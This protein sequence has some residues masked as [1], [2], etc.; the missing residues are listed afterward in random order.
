MC[1]LGVNRAKEGVKSR[2]VPGFTFNSRLVLQAPHKTRLS[3]SWHHRSRLHVIKTSPSLCYS[4]FSLSGINFLDLM[5]RQGLA[6]TLL[7]PPFVMGSECA[8]I[9]EEVGESVQQFKLTEYSPKKIVDFAA[10]HYDYAQG[11]LIL[12]IFWVPKRIEY[13][14]YTFR[15]IVLANLAWPMCSP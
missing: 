15:S 3:D 10:S 12:N 8:G 9:I 11:F 6:D 2:T 7:K 4:L 5:I 1:V 13:F 14:Q